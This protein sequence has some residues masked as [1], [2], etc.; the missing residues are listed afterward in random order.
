MVGEEGLEVPTTLLLTFPLGRYHATPWDRHVNEGDV[1]IPPS[2]WRLLRTLYAVWKTRC[3]DLPADIVEPL[4]AELAAPPTFYVPA[5]S[6]AHSRHWYPDANDGTDRTLDAFAVF[7]PDDQL[8]VQWPADLSPAHRDTLARIA[9]SIPYFGRADSICVGTLDNNWAPTGHAVWKPLDVAEHIEH[10]TETASVLAPQMPLFIDTL[11]AKPAEVRRSGL[12]FPSGSRLVAYGLEHRAD[13]PVRRRQPRPTRIVTA[14]RFDLLHAALPPDTDTAIY[15]DLLRQA[16]IKQLGEHPEG[17]MLGGKTSDGAPMQGGKHAHYLPL[18]RERRLT[19]F[20]VWIPGGLDEKEQ[21]AL[22]AV[23]ALYDYKHRIQVRVSGISAVEKIIPELVGPATVWNTVTP[24][25]PSRFPKKGRDVWADFVAEEIQR[26]LRLRNC[27]PATGIDFVDGPWTSFVRHRPSARLRTDKR[28]GQAHL[29]A[30]FITLRF[31]ESVTGPL[32]LGRL[33]H[34]GL[35]LF[36][37]Q[38]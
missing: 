10:Y 22:C 6:I 17:T 14:V 32:A 5:H 26:E 1:E 2:P 8:A 35:G 20:V 3:P 24:F 31:N 21:D 16:A 4:L 37:P 7:G 13:T 12:K 18:I 9:E 33:S 27:E 38:R 19:G 25:T 30:Q 36:A 29:P 15:T 28:Q 34:F 11:L 23:R